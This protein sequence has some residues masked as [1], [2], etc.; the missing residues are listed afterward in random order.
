MALTA[1]K[2]V[3]AWGSNHYGQLGLGHKDYIY[4]PEEISFFTDRNIVDI[5][6]GRFHSI[7]LS[8]DGQVY[9]WGLSSDCQGAKNYLPEEISFFNDKEVLAIS[10]STHSSFV[11][12]KNKIYHLGHQT[13]ED[14][15]QIK[16]LDFLTDK[17]IISV[18]AGWFHF[19]ALSK[20]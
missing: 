6:S 16:E 20:D 7:A 4:Y 1:N 5:D 11:F 15:A 3:Y 10:A 17:N 8:R 19:L 14:C 13:H 9:T 18:E 2:K 12:T